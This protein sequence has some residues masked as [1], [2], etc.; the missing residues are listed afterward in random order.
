MTKLELIRTTVGTYKII[1]YSN[2]QHPVL[3][4]L[5]GLLATA[6]KCQDCVKVGVYQVRQLPRRKKVCVTSYISGKSEKMTKLQY[7]KF[8][9]GKRQIYVPKKDKIQSVKQEWNPSET[10]KE[11]EEAINSILS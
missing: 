8:M 1:S 3:L 4:L 2:R 6:N 9:Q 5:A 7:A 10:D 11:I